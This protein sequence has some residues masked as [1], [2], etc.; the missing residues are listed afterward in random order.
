M[1]R[2][3]PQMDFLKDHNQMFDRRGGRLRRGKT[4]P[5]EN[6]QTEDDNS[7]T[8]ANG[9]PMAFYHPAFPR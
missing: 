4:A 8:K 7:A 9:G 2:N 5:A 3:C 1:A 6:R